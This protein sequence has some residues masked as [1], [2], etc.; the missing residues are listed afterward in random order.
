MKLKS[1]LKFDK[2]LQTISLPKYNSEPEGIAITLGW[3]ATI[4]PNPLED[5]FDPILHKLAVPLIDRKT[6]KDEI[7]KRKRHK[8][9]GRKSI[10]TGGHG[11]VTPCNVKYLI[12]I[13]L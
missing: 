6:C 3:G 10:C 2:Y 1:P 11:G 4:S 13:L 7:Q 12:S 8:V 5:D 9:V